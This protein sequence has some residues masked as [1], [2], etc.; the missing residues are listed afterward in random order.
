M[1]TRSEAEL[2]EQIQELK[3]ITRLQGEPAARG[4]PPSGLRGP[5]CRTF[6]FSTGTVPG[7]W[8]EWSP[9]PPPQNWEQNQRG[10]P[11]RGQEWGASRRFVSIVGPKARG[12]RKGCRSSRDHRARLSRLPL[13][14]LHCPA[15]LA[16]AG[17]W[18][19]PE[20]RT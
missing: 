16:T 17:W 7:K 5:G 3:T 11:C 15:Q 19:R 1:K 10:L 9:H 14:C 6:H 12:D 13:H 8:S 20:G 4:P 2:D 18:P